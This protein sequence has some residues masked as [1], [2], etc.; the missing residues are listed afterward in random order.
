MIGLY[1]SATH[2]LVT[3]PDD[4]LRTLRLHFRYRPNDYWRSPK[5]ERWKATGGE[6]GWDGYLHPLRIVSDGVARILRGYRV[7]LLHACEQNGLEVDIRKLLPRPFARISLED[8]PP[9]LVTADFQLD[10]YQRRS[11]QQLLIYGNGVV[12]AS[13]GAGKT[14]MC[15]G[16][17]AMIKARYPDARFIYMTPTERLVRQSYAEMKKFLPEW[18]ISQFGGGRQ[19][20]S[21]KDMV[22]C[23]VAMLNRHFRALKASRWFD[24]F[25]CIL[26]DECFPATT[27][28]DGRSI[29]SFKTGDFVRSFD[30][31]TNTIRRHKITHV[32]KK[33][34]TYLIRLWLKRGSILCTPNHP[35]FVRGIGYMPAGLIAS[36]SFICSLA[37]ETT[38]RRVRLVWQSTHTGEALAK[39]T[40]ARRT[41]GLLLARVRQSTI[42]GCKFK[43]NDAHKFTLQSAIFS[44]DE[45]QKSNAKLCLAPKSHGITT[46]NGMETPSPRRKRKT[47]ASGTGKIS[48]SSGLD[49]GIHCADGL[50][51]NSRRHA[52]TLHAGYCRQQTENRR[53]SGRRL[54]PSHES[55]GTRCTSNEILEWERVD[56]VEILKPTSDGTFGGLCPDGYVYNLEVENNHNYFAD[57]YLVHNCQH[58]ASA[59]AEKV[60]LAIP[61]YFRFGASDSRK[62]DDPAKFNAILGLFGPMLSE[63]SASPLIQVGRL[64]RPHHYLVDIPAWQNLYKSVPFKPQ[65]NTGAIVLQGEHW[66]PGTYKGPVYELDKDGEIVHKTRRVLD[67][68]KNWIEEEVPVT[69]PGLHLIE[70]D[71]R[72][73]AVESRW[74]L[75]NRLYDRGIVR[76]VERN[77]L[78]TEW[79]IHFS[80][81]DFTTLVVVKRTLHVY[82]LEALIMKAHPQPDKVRILFGWATSKERDTAFEWFADTPGAVLISPLVQEGVSIPQIRAAVVADVVSDFERANQITGRVI[83][84]AEGK[85]K[86]EIVWF[87]ERQ[88]PAMRRTS[89]KVFSELEKIHGYVFLTPCAG[90]D[91]ISRALEFRTKDLDMAR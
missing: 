13:V 56:C 5:F 51:Q 91:S 84:S 24:L 85:E 58:A 12:Q 62:V 70:L 59:T 61:A 30:H 71:G 48:E 69:V 18:D 27:L 66:V 28:V 35:F 23:T 19:D 89:A 86:A 54:S 52:D 72:D 4:D 45:N 9:D 21:G 40:G 68:D 83:R 17:A 38:K 88:H 80:K 63:T 74:C 39:D 42:Q 2:I 50:S 78:I 34:P 14:M 22:V 16:C 15:S 37:H 67:D 43:D 64:V 47:I 90:P 49:Y 79:A 57:G 65:P 7:G 53:G 36:G 25:M 32:F 20:K 87:I 6:D 81:Q 73:E 10:D 44:T 3:G 29:A 75:L 33:R 46:S 26:F 41:P 1:E 55:P 31:A 60:L 77:N 11:I 82:I 8:V 76:F